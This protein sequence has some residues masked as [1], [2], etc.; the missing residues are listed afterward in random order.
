[1]T[2]LF[3]MLELAGI[4]L[5]ARRPRRAHPLVICRRAADLL[6]P[7]AARALRRPRDPGRARGADSR[8]AARGSR[9][10]GAR[11][12]S[13][14]ARQRPG[15]F[16]PGLH[17]EARPRVAKAEDDAAAGALADP[18]AS[19]RAAVD[20]PHR[21]RARLLARLHLLRDAPHHQR[22]HAHR[23]PERVL[24]LIPADA[25]A[26]RP[27][28]RGGDR[29][30]AHRRAGADARRRA[31]AR[32]A[33]HRCA[34]TVSRGR[35][36]GAAQ[37]R[38]REDPDHR[39]R[40]R[41][42]AAAQGASTARPT[43]AQLFRAAE[44]AREHGLR[45][46]QAVRDARLARRRRTRTSTSW[47]ARARA[48]AHHPARASACAPFVAKRNTPM[49]GAPFGPSG[50]RSAARLPAREA[51]Q[52]RAE[53]RPTR[54][55]WAWVEYMLAQGG[56][57]AGLA[58]MEAWRAAA[59]SRPGSAPSARPACSP[60]SRAGCRTA[61]CACRSSPPG[62]ASRR[63]ALLELPGSRPG[64]TAATEGARDLRAHR[65]NG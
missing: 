14:A 36:G 54:P 49:D 39:R 22:R 56:Q 58:A 4:P 46:A 16:V 1:M 63:R 61:A 47:C 62:R 50:D 11:R 57:D 2:G 17:G 26:R 41:L 3:E 33:S 43:R 53:M 30:P 28:R 19:H 15:F 51:P 12:C 44:L 24:E 31:G 18:H 37:A 59:R 21:A 6:Q 40:R 10:A 27:G 35:A 42:G 38:R 52:G 20:V 60:R 65:S 29:P 34:P 25:R 45:A 48:V 32:W 9:T 8:P 7:G 55:R 23:R 64:G 13:R 5:L